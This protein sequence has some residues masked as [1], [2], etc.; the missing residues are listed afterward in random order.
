MA[1]PTPLRTALFA[2]GCFWCMQ[3]AFDAIS[4]VTRTRVGYA[5]GTAETA[6]YEA[7]STG[8]TQHLEVIEIT[9]DPQRVRYAQLL[10]TYL[11]N[12]DPTQADGQF[13]DRGPQYHTAI[14]YADATQKAAAE[15]ALQAIAVK[16]A[17]APIVVHIIAAAP[18][19]A[20]EAYHQ[21]YYEKNSAHYTAYKRGSG[22][23]DYLE[24]TWRKG[25][26]RLTNQP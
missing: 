2:G 25:R 10:E 13:A 9:Y 24:R 1:A 22:R 26:E 8:K 3:P 12:I 15:K 23:A 21:K 5:G 7:V 4:G 17:P 11:E 18:F 20:A 6:N 14:F 16:F 19:Y